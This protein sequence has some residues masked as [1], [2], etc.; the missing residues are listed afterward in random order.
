MHTFILQDWTTI[1]GAVTTI[2]QAETD[3][4]DLSPYQDVVF[5]IDVKEST[6]T[7]TFTLQT[8][9]SKD[10][11]LFTALIPGVAP[12]AGTVSIQSAFMTTASVPLARFL[13]WQINGTPTWDATFRILVAANSPGM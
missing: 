1:R 4:L 13:R 8:S 9:P 11:S 6:N 5:W 2:V 12:T 7:P 10:D 3:W